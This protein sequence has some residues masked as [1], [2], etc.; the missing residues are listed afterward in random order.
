MKKGQVDKVTSDDSG[1]SVPV[2]ITRLHEILP[3][4]LLHGSQRE[5]RSISPKIQRSER[6]VKRRPFAIIF[7]PFIVI[8]LIIF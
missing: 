4:L 5:H 7:Q 6:R 3:G 8:K 1:D 2:S